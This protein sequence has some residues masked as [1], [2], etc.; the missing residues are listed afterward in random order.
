[1][2][3]TLIIV[4]LLSLVIV[5]SAQ[6][7]FTI[8]GTVNISEYPADHA[9]VEL[10]PN[11]VQKLTNENGFFRFTKLDSGAYDVKISFVGFASQTL[12]ID[13]NRENVT[14]NIQ[15]TPGETTTLENVVVAG[16]KNDRASG[17][18]QDISGTAIYARKKTELINLRN[19]NANLATNNTRQIYAR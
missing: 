16:Q 6:R 4:S 8:N 17:K 15:L 14:L 12:H 7:S 3:R 10:L 9:T 13:L 19:I 5:V 11:G 18:L 1:M 2:K